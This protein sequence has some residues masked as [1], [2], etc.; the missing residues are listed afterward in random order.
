MRKVVCVL[1]ALALVGCGKG[2]AN[3]GNAAQPNAQQTTDSVLDALAKGDAKVCADQQVMAAVVNGILQGGPSEAD[4]KKLQDS[5]G[6][7]T[8]QY[9]SMTG[10]NLDIK[11]VSCSGAIP[12]GPIL[13]YVVRPAANGDGFVVNTEAPGATSN[14]VYLALALAIDNELKKK[15]VSE[16]NPAKG[17]DSPTAPATDTATSDGAS[18]HSDPRV[19]KWI[20][21]NEDC[22]GSTEPD[23]PK[24]QQSCKEADELLAS[25]HNAG[26]CYGKQDQVEAEYDFHHCGKDSL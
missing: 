5:G 25:L 4:F 10:R 19:Q 20:K 16:D 13:K 11:E 14:Q 6:N 22:R 9:A 17:T 21:L 15:G 23:D 2:S 12:G 3:E 7:I 1:S 18:L 24:T 8:F 26:I